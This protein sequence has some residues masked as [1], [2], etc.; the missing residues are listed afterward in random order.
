[1]SSLRRLYES[2]PNEAQYVA[3]KGYNLT[4]ETERS[5]IMYLLDTNVI[6]TL[7]RSDLKSHPEIEYYAHDKPEQHT[8]VAPTVPGKDDIIQ[9]AIRRDR[10]RDDLTTLDDKKDPK[11][12][13]EC[14][15]PFVAEL[16][17]ITIFGPHAL[18]RTP[19][20]ELPLEVKANLRDR[21]G[22]FAAMFRSTLRWFGRVNTMKSIIDPG[23]SDQNF[24]V[25]ASILTGRKNTTPAYG[26]W[27]VEILPRIR[28]I[29]HYQRQTGKN[30]IILVNPNITDWQIETLELVGVDTSNLI[31][32]E[33]GQASV[34]RYV[35]PMWAKTKW[36]TSDIDWIREQI[37]NGVDYEKHL[38]R[39]SSRIYLSR[40]NMDRR[41][42]TNREQLVDTISDYGFESYSPES[43]KFAEQ[44]ALFKQANIIIGPTGSSFTNIIFSADANIIELFQP[45]NFITWQFELSQVLDH[46]YHALFGDGV[47]EN[48][49]T[50][51]P[52]HQDFCISPDQVTDL[53]EKII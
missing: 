45:E 16:P 43:M 29:K 25:A 33:G 14:H 21:G 11:Y 24:E 39:F 47:D 38:D 12:S 2:L 41:Q 20:R 13:V 9:E 51:N 34:D 6:S 28:R 4:K 7:D 26:H 37:A 32:W 27:L 36:C 49:N 40:A 10:W 44:V 19:N 42:V 23:P 52:H 1:M 18:A 35:L 17:N 30:P 53:L 46:E 22:S 8:F 31:K 5:T 48:D 3:K 50:I 15:E